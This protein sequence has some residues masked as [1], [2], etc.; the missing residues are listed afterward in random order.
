MSSFL[1]TGKQKIILCFSKYIGRVK[2][3]TLIAK[4]YLVT[5]S[6]ENI[7]YETYELQKIIVKIDVKLYIRR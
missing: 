6:I 4:L 1:Y 5:I 3:H 7:F 2:S